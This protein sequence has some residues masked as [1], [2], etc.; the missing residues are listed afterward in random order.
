MRRAEQGFTLI[1]LLVALAV[2]S[3]AALALVNVA[4]ENARSAHGLETRVLAGV[5]ADNQAIA[6]LTS[7][8]PP[9]VGTTSGIEKQGGLDWRWTRRISRTADAAILRADIIVSARNRTVAEATVFR[10]AR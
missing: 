7:P 2:F 1:E 9:A 4:S 3:L 5:V 10:S 8:R 6:F